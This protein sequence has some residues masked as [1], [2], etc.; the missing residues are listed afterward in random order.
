MLQAR[1]GAC[2]WIGNG[3]GAG[4]CLLHMPRYDFNDGILSLGASCWAT[5]VE[6]EL[7]ISA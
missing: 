2:G 4:G 3:P 6:R 1:P 7:P 5:L